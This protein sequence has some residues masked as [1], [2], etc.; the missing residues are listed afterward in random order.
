MAFGE[1]QYEH[2]IFVF[3]ETLFTEGFA[4]LLNAQKG[5]NLVGQSPLIDVAQKIIQSTHIDLIIV[6]STDQNKRTC[7]NTLIFKYPHLSFIFPDPNDDTIQIVSSRLIQLKQSSSIMAVIQ[8]VSNQLKDK[9]KY[10]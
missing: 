3:G 5:F 1:A 2:N 8:M 7:I 4:Y 10:Q 6:D 9:H